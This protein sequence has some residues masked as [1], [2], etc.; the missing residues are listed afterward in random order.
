MI[1]RGTLNQNSLDLRKFL[2]SWMGKII[3]IRAY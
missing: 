2:R 3:Y 1:I